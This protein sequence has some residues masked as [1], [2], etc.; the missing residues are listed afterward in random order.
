MS[1]LTL[2]QISKLTVARWAG[3]R[4]DVTVD[5]EGEGL[6]IKHQASGRSVTVGP[7]TQPDLNRSE[8]GF[9]SE[10]IAPALATLKERIGAK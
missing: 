8:D 4:G 3:Y 9:L 5:L 1:K 7:I 2:P 10:V 6:M